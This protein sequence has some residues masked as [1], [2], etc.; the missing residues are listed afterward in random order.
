MGNCITVNRSVVESAE[1]MSKEYEEKRE[2]D[3]VKVNKN[4]DNK[5]YKRTINIIVE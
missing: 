3:Q 5:S 4:S 2:N 1:Y